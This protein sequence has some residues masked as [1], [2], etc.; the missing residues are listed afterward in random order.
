MRRYLFYSPASVTLGQFPSQ[1]SGVEGRDNDTPLS[2][3]TPV[4]GLGGREALAQGPLTWPH[5]A[6]ASHLMNQPRS[7]QTPVFPVCHVQNRVSA[8]PVGLNGQKVP[9]PNC[10][11][12]ERGL[13]SWPVGARREMPKP[14]APRRGPAGW[15]LRGGPRSG[16][17]TATAEWGGRGGAADRHTSPPSSQG[18]PWRPQRS[19]ISVR[20]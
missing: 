16:V 13:S 8:P 20:P 6:C 15:E 11:C 14:P 12:G 3:Y 18:A 9:P 10:T 4:P 1:D 2:G 17:P 5:L 7:T 19:F